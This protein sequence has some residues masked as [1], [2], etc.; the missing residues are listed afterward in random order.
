MAGVKDIWKNAKHPETRKDAKFGNQSH[1]DGKIEVMSFGGVMSLGLEKQFGGFST[2]IFQG[3][4]PFSF[5]F[6]AFP[7]E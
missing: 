5:E 7:R 2:K 1:S 3:S 6:N 4:G